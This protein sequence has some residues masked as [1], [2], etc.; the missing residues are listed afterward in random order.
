MRHPAPR[1]EGEPLLIHREPTYRQE[2]QRFGLLTL[3]RLRHM[4]CIGKTGSGKS[5]LLANLIVQDLIQGQGLMLLDPHGDL[6]EGVL[7]F[8]P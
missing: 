4:W 7:P 5:T 1:L 8:V 6:V 2:H 3:D